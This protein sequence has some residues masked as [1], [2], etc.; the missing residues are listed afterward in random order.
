MNQSNTFNSGYAEFDSIANHN[1][2]SGL[3]TTGNIISD[4]VF[5]FHVRGFYQKQCNGFSFPSGAL[6][7]S[8]LSTAK[9]NYGREFEPVLRFI[10]ASDHFKFDNGWV[11]LVRHVRKSDKKIVLHGAV[12]TTEQHALIRRFD[13]LELQY[14]G[15]RQFQ[16]SRDV[17]DSVTPMISIRAT[18]IAPAVQ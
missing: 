6:Q 5:G 2:G 13:R 1:S 9:K 18:G 10:T 14:G 16:K 7:A 11:Y 3:I 17:M 12:I 8:D 4:T 15:F